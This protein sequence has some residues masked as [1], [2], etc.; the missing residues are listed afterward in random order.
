MERRSEG[1][2]ERERER[3]KETEGTRARDKEQ[4]CILSPFSSASLAIS[5]LLVRICATRWDPPRRAGE[6]GQERDNETQRERRRERDRKRES[7][8]ASERASERARERK[9]ASK[10]EGNRERERERKS[11]RVPFVTWLLRA[12]P[13]HIH[14]HHACSLVEPRNTFRYWTLLSEQCAC[15]LSH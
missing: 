1:A 12:S 9:K 2:S 4:V 8:R 13:I 5:A 3:E 10:R 7:K 15:S 6:G 14:H 11:T